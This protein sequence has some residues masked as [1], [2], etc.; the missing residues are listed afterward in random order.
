MCIWISSLRFNSVW[1]WPRFWGGQKAFCR[2]FL[3]LLFWPSPDNIY[4]T[5][6]TPVLPAHS[7]QCIIQQSHTTYTIHYT[8]Y[9]NHTQHTLTFTHYT[10]YTHNTRNIHSLPQNYITSH[11]LQCGYW[12]L[13]TVYA[14][15]LQ[16]YI[17]K[18]SAF[19]CS[20]YRVEMYSCDCI[21]TVH[22]FVPSA[23][24]CSVQV[25]MCTHFRIHTV[26]CFVHFFPIIDS[27]KSPAGSP[28]YF[29]TFRKVTQFYFGKKGL[30]GWKMKHTPT[31]HEIVAHI[32]F[33]WSG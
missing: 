8:H 13:F 6:L 20:H 9:T 3:H 5:V 15:N 22:C 10:Q 33:F 23:V 17:D 29:S 18:V 27:F 30:N 2:Y 16:S 12:T 11:I 1:D 24:L 32:C 7:V 31:K 19:L 26:R 21:H 28:A 4:L 14:W 25:T